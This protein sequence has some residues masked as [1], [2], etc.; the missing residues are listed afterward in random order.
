MFDLLNPTA[1]WGAVT[2]YGGVAA[3]SGIIL[4]AVGY[5]VFKRMIG[6]GAKKI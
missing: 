4:A 3:V 1:I 5:R 6:W 2:Q